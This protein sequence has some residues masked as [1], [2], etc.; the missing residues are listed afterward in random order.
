MEVNARTNLADL[1]GSSPS[2]CP[3]LGPP[4]RPLGTIRAYTDDATPSAAFL[5]DRGCLQRRVAGA[6]GRALL[7]ACSGGRRRCDGLPISS[8]RAGRAP[9]WVTVFT[10]VFPDETPDPSHRIAPDRTGS[11]WARRAGLDETPD[12]SHRTGRGGLPGCDE[13]PDPSRRVVER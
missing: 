8:R 5:A 6:P 12:P 4:T 13:F 2:W 11:H 3:H 1:S 7:A 10:P 9:R